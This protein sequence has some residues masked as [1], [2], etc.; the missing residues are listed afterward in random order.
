MSDPSEIELGDDTVE[1]GEEPETDPALAAV[2][3]QQMAAAAANNPE[4]IE[5]DF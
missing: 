4:E 5:L 3:G 1:D 2:L